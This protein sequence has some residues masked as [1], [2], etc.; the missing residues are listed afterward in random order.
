MTKIEVICNVCG[1]N[2]GLNRPFYAV[3]HLKKYPTHRSYRE[4][5]V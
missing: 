1:E 4:I 5:K 3:E 2:L